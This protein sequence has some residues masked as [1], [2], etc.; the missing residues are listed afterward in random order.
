MELSNFILQLLSQGTV[1]VQAATTS[2]SEDDKK[3]TIKILQQYYSEDILEMPGA[4]PAFDEAAALWASMFFY[5]AVHFTVLR[6]EEETVVKETLHVFAGPINAGAIYSADLILRYLPA[7]V[8]L[9]K[10]L[11]PADIL[12]KV[13]EQ[14]GAEWPF[15]STGIEIAVAKNEAGIFTH[16]SLAIAYTD[17]LI[18]AKDITRTYDD[19]LQQ[20]ILS[21][22]GLHLK[23]F[24]PQAGT[25]F[26]NDT[27]G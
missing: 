10:G 21:A 18:A 11:S 5:N 3:E 8:Q 22:T 4:A 1:S 25:I 9:A 20:H 27:N 6:D 16:P 15:S 14:T 24:W 17:R 23:K 13:L 2:F 19:A 12:V 7:L 26:K